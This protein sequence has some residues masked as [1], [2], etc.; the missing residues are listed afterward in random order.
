MGD[1]ICLMRGLKEWKE[2]NDH[3]LDFMSLHAM[4]LEAAWHTKD[5]F[6]RVEHLSAE[7]FEYMKNNYKLF[8]YD[9][10]IDHFNMDW[11]ESTKSGIV[12]AY[13]N[14]NFGFFPSTDRPY[15]KTKYH[16]R[17]NAKFIVDRLR[18]AGWKRFAFFQALSVSNP[19][20]SIPFPDTMAILSLFPSDTMILMPCGVHDPF[21]DTI[22]PFPRNIHVMPGY[23]VGNAA[24]LMKHMDINLMVHGA[25]SHI[26][27]AVNA[28][29]VVQLNFYAT[30]SINFSIP[31]AINLN[32]PSNEEEYMPTLKATID[33]VLIGNVS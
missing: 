26:A 22:N 5:L 9:E 14:L 28:P 18:G 25:Y 24:A 20:R 1:A 17:V 2:K 4:H 6:D 10:V 11:T 7:R 32:F 30:G 8:G 27:Y 23:P 19:A 15:F 12:N 31:G 21:H 16:E 29:N 33:E 13:C 3:S